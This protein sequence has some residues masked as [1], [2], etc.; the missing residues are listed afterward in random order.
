MAKESFQTFRSLI[1][2]KAS[3]MKKIV[4]SGDSLTAIHLAEALQ[5]LCEQ[6]ILAD[7]DMEHGRTAAAM[8]NGVDVFHLDC[9]NSDML[10][11]INIRKTD[12]FIAAGKD[13]ED[14]IMSCLMA[15]AEGAVML[16]QDV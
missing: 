16:Q 15:K 11:E 1:N 4:V 12:C 9:T 5:P 2:R 13:Q 3:K 14:N 7:P 6:V 10:E 8:L